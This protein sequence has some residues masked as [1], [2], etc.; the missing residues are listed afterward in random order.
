MKK[1]KILSLV[2]KTYGILIT[3]LMLFA[4]APKLFGSTDSIGKI[5]E[6]LFNLNDEPTGFFFIYILGYIFV[7]WK[8][9]LGSII[10][11]LGSLLF[12]IFNLNNTSFLIIFLLP[13]FIVAILYI[14]HWAITRSKQTS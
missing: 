5:P 4:F 8:P 1:V 2:S 12:L 11:M 3:I 9:L 13:T 7:W 14:W 6:H 10:I